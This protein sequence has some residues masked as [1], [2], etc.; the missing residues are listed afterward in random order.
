M[1]R[2]VGYCTN[3]GTEI[4][5]ITRPRGKKALPNYAE[6]TM[7][8]SDGSMLKVAVCTTCK[9]LL[10]SG[11]KVEETANRI[12]KH[13]KIYWEQHETDDHGDGRPN[14]F[15]KLTVADP[16]TNALKIRTKRLSSFDA[17]R[18]EKLAAERVAMEDRRIYR[19]SEE[20]RL[21]DIEKFNDENVKK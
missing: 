1:K 15:D 2:M 5:D 4:M 21:K 17:D 3:C 16:G 10:V 19:E 9:P 8:L 11:S 18:E 14:R 12:L 13:H 6:H 20:K 7:E